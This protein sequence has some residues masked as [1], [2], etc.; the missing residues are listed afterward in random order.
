MLIKPNLIYEIYK[1]KSHKLVAQINNYAR[2]GDLKVKTNC[3]KDQ[4][5]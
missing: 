5:E 4:E 1:P 2:A 3:A